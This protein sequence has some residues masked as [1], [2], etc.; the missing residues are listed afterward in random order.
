MKTK[1]IELDVDYLGSQEP[2]SSVDEK[3]L[4]DYFA[5]KKELKK[6]RTIK[7]KRKTEKVKV[8]K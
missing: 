1:D 7:P 3:V 8:E 4:N 2:L 5:N 6:R